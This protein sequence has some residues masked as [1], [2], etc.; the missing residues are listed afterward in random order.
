[1]ILVWRGEGIVVAGIMI[2][3]AVV[4]TIIGIGFQINPLFALCLWALINAVTIYFLSRND[5]DTVD[6]FYFIPVKYW[7]HINIVM[8]CFFVAKI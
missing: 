6:T 8:L 1:M 2:I 7:A 3:S 5:K 4:S